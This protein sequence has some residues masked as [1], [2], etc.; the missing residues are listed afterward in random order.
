M[1]NGALQP[2]LLEFEQLFFKTIKAGA[3]IQEGLKPAIFCGV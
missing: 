1:M 3:T 2:Q